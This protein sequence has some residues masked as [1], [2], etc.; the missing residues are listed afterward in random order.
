LKERKISGSNS[1]P[2]R[3]KRLGLRRRT[4]RIPSYKV[5]RISSNLRK[6]KRSKTFKCRLNSAF[7]IMKEN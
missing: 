2:M 6:R 5:L 1:K 3:R 4:R 7:E